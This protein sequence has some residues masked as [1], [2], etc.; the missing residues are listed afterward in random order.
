MNLEPPPESFKAAVRALFDYI[1]AH[2]DPVKTMF[3]DAA[4][5]GRPLAE[6]FANPDFVKYID[7]MGAVMP[8]AGPES[9][10]QA[11]QKRF[12]PKSSSSAVSCGCARTIWKPKPSPSKNTRSSFWIDFRKI[13]RLRAGPR[14]A[15]PISRACDMWSELLNLY[16]ITY[17]PWPAREPWPHKSGLSDQ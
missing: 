15:Q 6:I 13:L 12:W 5:P 7:A 10:A 14:T 8:R 2:E 4:R 17:W 1:A 11:K 3:F 16:M 9:P